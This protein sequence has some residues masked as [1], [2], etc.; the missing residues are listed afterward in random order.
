VAGVLPVMVDGIELLVPV[1]ATDTPATVAATL[2][3]LINTQIDPDLP[4]TAVAGTGG[5]A[6][7][8]TLTAGNAGTE[9]NN[10]GLAYDHMPTQQIPPGMLVTVTP[11]SGGTLNPSIASVITAIAGML[12]SDIVMPWQDAANMAALQAELDARFTATEH[13]DAVAW[14]VLTGSYA[15][16]S[17]EIAGYNSRF[18]ASLGV[19][20]PQSAPWE[21]G[22]AMGSACAMELFNRPS[23]QLKNVVL[24]GITPPLPGDVIPAD[25]QQ[26]LLPQGVSTYNVLP[27]G[28]MVLQKIVSQCLTDPATG[29]PTTAWHDIMAAKVA[30]RIRYDWRIYVAQLYPSNTLADDGSLAAEYDPG[31]ATCNRLAGSW[32]A[33]M[34]VYGKQGW[35]EDVA[36]QAKLAIFQRDPNNHDR[37][38]SKL[39]YLRVGNLMVLACM[40]QFEI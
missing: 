36:N 13:L 40:Q 6:G 17:T 33:R 28:T 15:G 11:M 29:V 2:V 14:T 35:I 12:Y 20:N 23:K 39:P 32:G 7:T 25:E 16:I 34:N 27:D 4:V 18:N 30:T 22:A 24:I 31:V 19:T 21:I 5:T 10:I 38:N 3:A 37:V 9:S 8:V 26:L 1:Q